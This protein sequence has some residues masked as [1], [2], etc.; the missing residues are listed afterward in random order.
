M[1]DIGRAIRL[2]IW[3]ES[4]QPRRHL[5]VRRVTQDLRF[6]AQDNLGP[7]ARQRAEEDAQLAGHDARE[8][9]S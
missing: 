8:Q 7:D 5:T 4:D 2:R 6:D 9:E 1:S 3:S